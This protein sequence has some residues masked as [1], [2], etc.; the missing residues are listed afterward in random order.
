MRSHLEITVDE[1][2]RVKLTYS[3]DQ[4]K[5][6]RAVIKLAKH[7]EEFAIALNIGTIFLQ[8]DLEA[9]RLRDEMVGIINNNP[10]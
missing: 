1:S 2:G 4:S 7:E 9:I 10:E 5:L 8:D 3:G 6:A